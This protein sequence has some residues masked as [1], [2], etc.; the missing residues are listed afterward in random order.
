ME[1]AAA[2]EEATSYRWNKDGTSILPW[3]KEEEDV[4]RDLVLPYESS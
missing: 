1:A 2:M 4:G 3:S